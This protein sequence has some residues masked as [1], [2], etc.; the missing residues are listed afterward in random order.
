M[1]DLP[2]L[3]EDETEPLASAPPILRSS[4]AASSHNQKMRT[5]TIP[6]VDKELPPLP[7]EP[8]RASTSQRADSPDIKTILATTP[9]PRRKSSGSCISMRSRSPSRS[10]S[11][12]PVRTLRRHVSEGMPSARSKLRKMDDGARRTSEASLPLPVLRGRPQSPT[13]LAYAKA[14]EPWNED[15]F[16]SDYGVQLDGTGTP[17]DILDREEEERLERELEGED[18][19]TD[20]DLDIHTPLP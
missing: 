4:A 15:S 2:P 1:H 9:R 7:A 17:I 19:D 20:S 18:S 8:P 13:E 12:P 14:E 11:R 16:V 5:S 10:R 6:R 3:Q